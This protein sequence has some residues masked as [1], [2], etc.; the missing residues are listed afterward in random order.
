MK[1]AIISGISGQ[2]GAYL[3][4]LLVSKNYKVY[5]LVRSNQGDGLWRLKFLKIA[6]QVELLDCDLTDMSQIFRVIQSIQPDEVYHLA[7]QSSVSA[8]FVQPI[9]TVN[10]NTIST[11]N[12]LETIRL[13]K[14]SLKFYQ[15]SSSE[16]FG[17]VTSLPINET[18]VINPQSP[19]AI[20][21]A[22]GY[23][24]VRNYRQA[25]NL[26][27]TSGILFNH[28]SALRQNTFVIKKII[29]TALEIHEHGEGKLALGN[30]DVRRDFGYAP[31]YVNAMWLIMQQ[32][33]A[34]DYIICS[35]FSSSIREI[36][37]LVFSILNIPVDRLVTE[38]A[39]FRPADISENY[40]NP[41]KA[42]KQLNWSYDWPLK[43]LINQLI[44]D[45]K[46]VREFLKH[47]S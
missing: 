35:G 12:L 5:G 10:Y 39:L 18:N 21:K 38:K 42:K 34:D 11:L 19:Y 26:F 1:K 45:E 30:I 2:D 28:E 25:Y 8:S 40:G 47:H 13:S 36:V 23:W 24:M 6:D 4:R 15:A 27:A 14:A 31:E 44:E 43:K 16:M 7:A 17:E 9:A 32:E 41:E 29:K 37:E 22:T 33:I 20:S 46:E 3:A